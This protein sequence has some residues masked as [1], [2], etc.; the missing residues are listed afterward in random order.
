MRHIWALRISTAIVAAILPGGAVSA[1][2]AQ[3]TLPVPTAASV[4][5]IVQDTLYV[6]APVVV[7]GATLF[8][9]AVP[10]ST[11]ASELPVEARI[12]DIE[13]ALEEILAKSSDNPRASTVFDPLS[14]RVHVNRMRDLAVLEAVDARH[15]TPL[16]IV[17][18]TEDDAKYNASELGAL[19]NNWGAIAQSALIRA[20]ERRQ[21][22]VERRNL[23]TI[24]RVAIVLAALS[25]LVRFLVVYLR[26][27]SRRLTSEI[28][29]REDASPKEP[30]PTA[31]EAVPTKQRRRS[32][33]L[34]LLNLAPTRQLAVFAAIDETLLWGIAL[35]WFV[36]ITWSL[37]LFATTTPI[38]QA[39]FHGAFGVI[40]TIILTGLLNR[41]LD[42][43]IAQIGTPG[44]LMRRA[45]SEEKARLL[46]R[47]PTIVA[48]ISG[49]KTFILFFVAALSVLGQI[50]VPIGSVVPIGGVAAIALSL[51]AQNIV[52]DFLNG[53]LVLF[54]DQYVIG[55]YVTINAFSGIVEQLTLRMVQLRT[56]AGELVTIPHS[57]AISVVNQSRNWSRVDYRVPIDPASDVAKA[58]EIVRSEIE[59]LARDAPWSQSILEPIEW[60][61]IDG[62]SKDSAIVR[63]SV[64]TAP[65]RQF[66][67]RREINAHVL[68]A[69]AAARIALGAP[70]PP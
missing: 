4:P 24:A 39:I 50:G 16:P 70:I 29:A 26:Q 21:P 1:Q 55:D 18:V 3:L 20:L 6:S 67:L 31:E 9:V 27:R 41:I 30:D 10:I 45:S 42:I 5:G 49:A 63:A 56:T 62:L 47:A 11:P 44:R 64:R 14:L 61:G 54:E 12:A 22:A 25:L 38:A 36:A 2:L 35:A 65:L 68:V 17:T 23:D 59:A 34:A 46:L 37:S 57:A 48:A 58:V 13:T 43:A 60:I 53:F 7:D 40:T 32:F 19:S 28:A 33:A 69:F 66:E 51:S 15:R 52:R 8:R